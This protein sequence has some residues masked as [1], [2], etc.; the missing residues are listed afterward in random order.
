MHGNVLGK[1]CL[2]VYVLGNSKELNCSS[3]KQQ[4][5][6]VGQGRRV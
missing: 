3:Y 1:V 4:A 2:N 5:V 6:S